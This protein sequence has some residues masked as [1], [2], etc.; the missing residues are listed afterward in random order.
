MILFLVGLNLASAYLLRNSEWWLIIVLAYVWGGTINHSLTLA[1][2]E[3]SHGL[4]FE[5]R[6]LNILFGYLASIPHGLPTFITFKKFHLIHHLN[7]GYKNIDTDLP[8]AMEG[9]F[10]TTKL[11]KFLFLFF[12]PFF[13][14]FRPMI[15]YPGDLSLLEGV[16]YVFQFFFDFMVIKYWGAKALIYLILGLLLGS[17]L[18]PLAS[19]FIAEHYI[20]TDKKDKK[21]NPI[22]TYSYYGPLNYLTFFVGYH[23]EHHDF[24]QIPG[25][26]LHNL[27]K[28]APEYYEEVR[29]NAHKSW[30]AC[31]YRFIMDPTITPFKRVVR[32]IEEK[33]VDE[34]NGR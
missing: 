18:H 5:S 33:K 29:A 30:V 3:L 1:V 21:G 14:S 25:S 23:N 4:V 11:S 7:Q 34:K 32:V 12:Q 19:H 8:T 17:G 28:I 15:L 22:E 16:Q 31:L 26:R 27:H 24:P 13:Y 20:W 9:R 10:F 6:N 2:H